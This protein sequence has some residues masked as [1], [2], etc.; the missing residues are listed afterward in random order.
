MVVGIRP[1]DFML[2]DD[3]PE[4]SGT[5]EIVEAL[6]RQSLVHVVL[7]ENTKIS[8]ELETVLARNF[9]IGDKIKLNVKHEKLH[10]FDFS[11][12]ERILCEI[13]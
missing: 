2:T 8:A 9:K 11:T 1:Q 10:F 12:K 4:I 7:S 6:G 5:V 3:D 13:K